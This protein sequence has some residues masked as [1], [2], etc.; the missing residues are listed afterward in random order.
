MKR[1]SLILIAGWAHT[2]QALDGL[3]SA[4]RA[5]YEVRVSTSSEIVTEKSFNTSSYAKGFKSE[6]AKLNG[7]NNSSVVVGWSAGGVAAL[8]AAS[9]NPDLI[10]G[11]VL[12]SATPKFCTEGGYPWG[13]PPRNLRAMILEIR[14]DPKTVL[15]RFFQDVSWP[16][17]EPEPCRKE[18][19]NAACHMGIERLVDGLHYLQNTDLRDRLEALQ[20]P[21]LVIHG[22]KD[23]IVPWQ[24]GAWLNHSLPNSR[25][26]IHEGVGHDICR[27]QPV[28]LASEIMEFL[29]GRC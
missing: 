4:L 2:A 20:I 12:I 11:L 15:D 22:R 19:V 9:E 18:K 17:V 16:V 21:T 1:R 8:E 24:A 28:V 27:Q 29:E 10:N 7:K 3:A 6:V 25:I 5:T 14:R 13:V 26:I 23:R